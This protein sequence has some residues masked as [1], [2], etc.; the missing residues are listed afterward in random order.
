MKNIAKMLL[1]GIAGAVVGIAT[2]VWLLRRNSV[3]DT[4]LMEHLRYMFHGDMDDDF[5][6]DDA[7]DIGEID[8]SD[9]C[10]TLDRM[11]IPSPASETEE[12]SD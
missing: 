2:L 9:D 10:I 7:D 12:P 3:E 8:A 6:D 11:T 4:S 5:F 1:S